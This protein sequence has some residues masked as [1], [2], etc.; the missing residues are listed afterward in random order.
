LCRKIFQEFFKEGLTFA[1]S[2]EV[3]FSVVRMVMM[4]QVAQ[5]GCEEWQVRRDVLSMALMAGITPFQMKI[6][7]K[8]S[9][10]I[11]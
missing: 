5:Q 6:D 3:L 2:F 8:D 9:K 4:Q 7:E 11:N 1:E 10:I